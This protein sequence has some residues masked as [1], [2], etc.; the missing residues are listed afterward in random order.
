MC[1]AETVEFRLGLTREDELA[2]TLPMLV[3]GGTRLA[4]LPLPIPDSHG[5]LDLLVDVPHPNITRVHV[6]KLRVD[7]LV[8]GEPLPIRLV[9]I[10]SESSWLH[11][12]ENR[13]WSGDL[14]DGETVRLWWT[15]DRERVADIADVVLPEGRPYELRLRFDWNADSCSF[16][17][18]GTVDSPYEAVVRSSV[19]AKTFQSAGTPAVELS[20]GTVGFRAN[21]TIRSGVS[22]HLQ[23]SGA[24]AVV[25]T[26]DAVAAAVIPN[27]G[28]T[29]N[30]L[31]GNAVK[32]GDML[33]TFSASE[34]SSTA[35]ARSGTLVPAPSTG[36]EH[37]AI[38]VQ[39]L[40][41]RAT[42]GTLSNVVDAFAFPQQ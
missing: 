40:L 7:A 36:S 4:G 23:S 32:A 11:Q 6:S 3:S 13:T 28:W 25:F 20:A 24:V 19:N 26:K 42:D 17:A 12:K 41:Y 14:E 9:R 38:L 22:V 31:P 34:T 8:D 15:V 37:L 5:H 27:V 10:D 33:S 18:E 30:G 16:Q 29:V 21:Y 2:R 1:D 35:Y 39:D